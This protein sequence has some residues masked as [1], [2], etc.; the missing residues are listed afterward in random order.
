MGDVVAAHFEIDD[1]WYRG[2]VCSLTSE[3]TVDVYYV[4]FGDSAVISRDLVRAL[5]WVK[6]AGR[7]GDNS[8]LP[9]PFVSIPVPVHFLLNSFFQ[10]QFLLKIFQLHE[11][12]RRMSLY[13]AGTTVCHI[14]IGMVLHSESLLPCVAC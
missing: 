13:G 2:R 14:I 11:I 3:E 10:F 7:D 12:E 8:S 5:R 1:A 6:L 9:I 4:D